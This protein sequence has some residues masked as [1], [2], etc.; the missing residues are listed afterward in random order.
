MDAICEKRRS[1]RRHTGRRNNMRN[2][3][4]TAYRARYKEKGQS[5]NWIW[6]QTILVSVFIDLVSPLQYMKSIFFAS[7]CQAMKRPP[8]RPTTPFS[9]CT[10]YL[11]KEESAINKPIHTGSFPLQPCIVSASAWIVSWG[12]NCL[13]YWDGPSTRIEP[14]RLSNGVHG[15]HKM[16]EQI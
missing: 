4:P 16:L 10:L 7:K 11:R 3:L 14:N 12:N 15:R 6:E 5:P 1:K 2:C 9:L 8:S 13:W